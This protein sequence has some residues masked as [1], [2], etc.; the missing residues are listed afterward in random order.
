MDGILIVLVVLVGLI[1][2]IFGITKLKIHPFIVLLLTTYFIGLLGGI[3]AVNVVE[4]MTEGFG[5]ILAAIG[6][7]IICGTI[8]GTMLERSG[9]AL[10]MADTI[11]NAIGKT[12]N[13]L[14][15]SITGAIVSIPVF[16]DSGF[17]VLSPLNKAMGARTNTSMAVMATAL[18]SGLYATHCLVPP[19]PGPIFMSET[20]NADL[21]LVIMLGLAVAIPAVIGGY[22]YAVFISSRYYVP[23]QPEETVESLREKYGSLPA[24]IP[25]FAPILVPIILIALKSI[26]EFPAT[27]FGEGHIQ[28]FLTFIG[29]PVTAL[30]IGVFLSLRLIPRSAKAL[31]SD[32]VGQGV[33]N[34]GM[35]LAI[36]GAGGALGGILQE[37]PLADAISGFLL[38]YEVGLLLPFLLAVLLKTAIGASTVVMLTVVGMI[39]PL[40]GDLGLTCEIGRALTVL[41]IGA[42]SMVVSHAND[43]YFWVV[44]KF[45]DMD[46]TTGYKTQTGFTLVQGIISIVVISLI[47]AI[48]I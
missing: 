32:W 26:A 35:I 33:V 10:T 6:I 43:S 30:I 38:Q 3:S 44:T 23:P 27:P 41:A 9:A 46:P 13:V 5:N 14:T 22:L 31:T 4:L 48:F 1:L 25:S 17:V 29:E 21:G 39:A 15:M 20:L 34:A 40:L 2:M 12:R 45:S 42:G 24:P 16:C 18:S 8:I 11:L 37:L 7:V 36:T 28:A 19:T 47:A